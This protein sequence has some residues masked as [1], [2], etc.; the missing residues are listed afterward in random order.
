KKH[1]SKAQ[2]TSLDLYATKKVLETQS[3][4]AVEQFVDDFL[5]P[6]IEKDDQVR[7]L[8]VQ[9]LKIDTKGVF[10]PVLI[11]EL[12][13]L[14]G[15]VFLE[16]PTAEIIIEV[17]A[18]IDF[19]EQFAEREDGSDLGS[20]E[21][22]GNHARCAIRIVASRSA[23][24]RGDTEPHKNGVVA[25]VKR[26][27]ENIYLIGMSDQKNVDFM[28]A[29]A[30]ACIEEISHL[31]LLKR[32]KFPGLVKPRYWESYK[33]D[34]YLIHLHNPKGAKYLYGAV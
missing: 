7:G 4:S 3:A 28:E 20:R 1:L 22:I 26:D 18:L 5:A 14:G 31:S 8:I 23:R 29:V 10:F 21:F 13:I 11:N 16:K 12:I 34:T 30:G 9:Y 15:K 24:E 32:Y 27:F 33:V 19:L 17:K 6:L 2:K 25:L